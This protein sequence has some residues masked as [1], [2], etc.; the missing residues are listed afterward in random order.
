MRLKQ[1]SIVPSGNSKSV[2]QSH[3]EFKGLEGV[4]GGKKRNL[5]AIDWGKGLN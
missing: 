4:G 2:Q 5:E 1:N 3:A